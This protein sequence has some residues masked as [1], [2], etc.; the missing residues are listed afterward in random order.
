[1]PPRD[2]GCRSRFRAACLWEGRR[3]VLARG[4]S[5]RSTPKRRRRQRPSKPVW[6]SLPDSTRRPSCHAR[7]QDATRP[8][9]A[10][11]RAR[12]KDTGSC[13]RS[14]AP[15]LPRRAS[16][17][18]CERL[19][20]LPD[21]R[22]WPA[23]LLE[24]APPALASETTLE[25]LLRKFQC[26]RRSRAVLRCGASYARVSLAELCRPGGYSREE[27]TGAPANRAVQSEWP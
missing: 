7:R 18:R 9:P 1:M 19:Q 25:Q 12:S 5:S 17:G 27:L 6:T 23:N 20:D 3:H 21:C 8:P 26:A 24:D 10:K 16:W 15:R 13:C 11:P 22:P 4:N 2:E 14:C